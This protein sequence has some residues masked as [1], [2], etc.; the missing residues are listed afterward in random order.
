[1]S[2]CRQLLDAWY[3]HRE[4]YLQPVRLLDGSKLMLELDLSPGPQVGALLDA[5]REAQAAGLVT[6]RDQ[7]LGFAR[8]RLTTQNEG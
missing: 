1:L 4:E 2:V 7:A 3:D 8:E 5:L 6:T